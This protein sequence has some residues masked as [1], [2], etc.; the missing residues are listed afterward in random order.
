MWFIKILIVPSSLGTA[1]LTTNTRI[2]R[3]GLKCQY[4]RFTQC[5]LAQHDI[6][7]SQCSF[8][9]RICCCKGITALSV[10]KYLVVY[11]S[12]P[13]NLDSPMYWAVGVGAAGAVANIMINSKHT[14]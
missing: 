8:H 1:M 7:V 2:C 11:V 4:N 3:E 5:L 9:Q 13:N 10:Y 14:G 12:T 6:C